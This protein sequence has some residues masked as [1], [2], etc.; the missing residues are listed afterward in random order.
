MAG[1]GRVRFHVNEFSPI[2]RDF[3]HRGDSDYSRTPE[4]V[5]WEFPFT[6][7][8]RS[9]QRSLCEAYVT[10]RVITAQ[11]V[12]AGTVYIQLIEGHQSSDLG[13]T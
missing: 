5:S 2:L 1:G 11:D 7:G 13:V 8:G 4:V 6:W 3:E 12:D 9:H 10:A